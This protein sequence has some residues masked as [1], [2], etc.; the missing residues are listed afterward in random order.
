MHEHDAS[1]VAVSFMP[2]RTAG[3][4]GAQAAPGR[5]GGL[6][7]LGALRAPGRSLRAIARTLADRGI[8]ARSG[9][10]FAPSTLWPRV[11][12]P[13]GYEQGRGLV[14]VGRSALPT[15]ACPSF[16]LPRRFRLTRVP[17]VPTP[18]VGTA[19][20]GIV[21]PVRERT[22][23]DAGGAQ[24]AMPRTVYVPTG[25]RPTRRPFSA[26]SPSGG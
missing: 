19:G 13:T 18:L 26:V 10:P 12:Q 9:R 7:P 4:G 6:L 2:Q 21:D 17:S 5:R 3:R 11:R 15:S 23:P 1:S 24:A 25:A 14:R 16:R 22:S 20:C 8:F